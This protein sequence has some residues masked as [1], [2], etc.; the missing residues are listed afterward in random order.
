MDSCLAPF[1]SDDP[2]RQSTKTTPS[3]PWLGPYYP[4]ALVGQR[5]SNVSPRFW[6]TQPKKV[7]KDL[8]WFMRQWPAF[9]RLLF[10]RLDQAI[11]VVHHEHAKPLQLT[12]ILI[13]SSDLLWVRTG[14]LNIRCYF[15]TMDPNAQNTEPITT[16]KWLG[17]TGSVLACPVKFPLFMSP[18][19]SPAVWIDSG[20]IARDL[21]LIPNP[22]GRV[23][24]GYW[25]I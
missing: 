19:G 24:L 20:A 11:R 18:E 4:T 1:L 14:P 17:S 22:R 23:E 6:L 7:L 13:S 21:G 5:P 15:E 10:H 2:N 12:A 16:E 3:N 8:H 9:N 25:I